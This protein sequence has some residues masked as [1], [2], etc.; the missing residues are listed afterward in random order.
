MRANSFAWLG[1]VLTLSACGPS[2]AQVELAERNLST[3]EHQWIE[4]GKEEALK[5]LDRYADPDLCA[6]QAVY[7]CEGY[8]SA[9]V[10]RL[11]DTRRADYS[12]TTA[13]LTAQANA[14]DLRRKLAAACKLRLAE[15]DWADGHEPQPLILK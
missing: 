2:R 4:C 9:Y 15:Q 6:E 5:C 11:K 8:Q 1:L 13:L 7:S 10:A 12:T 14:R 3:V